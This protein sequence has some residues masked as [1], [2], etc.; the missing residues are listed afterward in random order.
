MNGVAETARYASSHAEPATGVIA[1][2]GEPVGFVAGTADPEVA[3]TTAYGEGGGGAA[4]GADVA[5]AAGGPDL[6]GD[7]GLGLL[8][9]QGRRV[10][11]EYAAEYSGAQTTRPNVATGTDARKAGGFGDSIR[12]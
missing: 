8:A 2:V 11:C 1:D 4:G 7:A 10:R 6:R 12:A 3:L 9:G 5:V